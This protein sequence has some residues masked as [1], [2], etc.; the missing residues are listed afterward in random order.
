[1]DVITL[2]SQLGVLCPDMLSFTCYFPS[3]RRTEV[4]AVRDN[5]SESVRSWNKL[6]VLRI[7]FLNAEAIRRVSCFPQFHALFLLRLLDRDE[8]FHRLLPS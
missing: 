3:F 6:Q 5:I 4:L 1:M 8:E 7:P 2:L